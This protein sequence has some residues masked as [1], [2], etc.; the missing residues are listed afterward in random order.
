MYFAFLVIFS[1]NLCRKFVIAES[2]FRWLNIIHLW[3]LRALV[4]S[5]NIVSALYLHAKLVT[6]LAV[7]S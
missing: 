3:S 2:D 4:V 7:H 5:S 6:T 1:K